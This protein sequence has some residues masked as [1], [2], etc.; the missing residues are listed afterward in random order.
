MS[1][2]PA[3][4]PVSDIGPL[5]VRLA[6]AVQTTRLSPLQFRVGIDPMARF[7]QGT[8]RFPRGVPLQFLAWVHENR[9]GAIVPVTNLM[10]SYTIMMRE[11]RGG[12]GTRRRTAASR[13]NRIKTR[14]VKGRIAMF[15]PNR[16][17]W[18]YVIAQRLPMLLERFGKA[19]Q[20]DLMEMA[21]AHGGRPRG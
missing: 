13:R 14:S 12:Y 11:G 18:S 21:I 17:V 2:R 19:V 9:K 8:L 4:R 7:P 10:L 1:R 20:K 5:F 15:P 6:K 16:P 3:K